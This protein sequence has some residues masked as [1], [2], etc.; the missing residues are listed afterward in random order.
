MTPKFSLQ[1]VLDV[2][3][4]RVEAVEIQLG[5]AMAA[6]E[7]AQRSL[8]ALLARKEQIMTR[9]TSI[10]QGDLD[11]VE[12]GLLRADLE[13]MDPSIA[14]AKDALMAAHH[15]VLH[16]RAQ[17][18]EAKQAEEVL[19]I[20]KR[21]RIEIFDAEQLQKEARAQDDIYIARAFQD[22]RE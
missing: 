4:T 2:R 7:A 20:L 21:K 17:L 15:Q 14:A 9:L 10:M 13:T 22:L 8:D 6:E 1:N 3:H 19:K 11:L 12:V 5:R 18:V 16:V